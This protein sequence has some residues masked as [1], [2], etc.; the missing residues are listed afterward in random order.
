MNVELP[1]AAPTGFVTFEAGWQPL[2]PVAHLPSEVPKD[3][4]DQST[5]LEFL[6]TLELKVVRPPPFRPYPIAWIVIAIGLVALL[7]VPGER[8]ALAPSPLSDSDS[9]L[10]AAAVEGLM[11]LVIA[12]G[13]AFLAYFKRPAWRWLT[14]LILVGA[15]AA[16]GVTVFQRYADLQ[17]SRATFAGTIANQ[18]MRRTCGGRQ[19]DTRMPGQL[20]WAV[21]HG[22]TPAETLRADPERYVGTVPQLGLRIAGHLLSREF[23]AQYDGRWPPE[24]DLPTH[25]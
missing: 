25:L 3:D 1:M 22:P 18:L 8:G 24:P 13:V 21:G 16:N 10:L 12:L 17:A 15:I 19:V 2:A 20:R 6:Q 5:L 4:A 7:V 11:I 14:T 23:Q 9:R